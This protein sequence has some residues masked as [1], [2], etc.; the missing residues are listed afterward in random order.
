MKKDF[1]KFKKE[2]LKFK[3]ENLKKIV[4]LTLLLAAILFIIAMPIKKFINR[5][6]EGKLYSVRNYS[7]LTRIL[8]TKDRYDDDFL[9][10]L[11]YGIFGF[12]PP[13][14]PYTYKSMGTGIYEDIAIPQTNSATSVPRP[15]SIGLEG[16]SSTIDRGSSSSDYSKTNVQIENIDEADIIKTDGKYVYSISEDYIVISDVL[17]KENPKVLHKLKSPSSTYPVDLLINENKLVVFSTDIARGSYNSSMSIIQVFDLSDINFPRKIKTLELN[18][19]YN[20]SRMIDNN[21]YIFSKKRLLNEN[22]MAL[23]NE[24]K[25]DYVTKTINYDNVKY[26]KSNLTDVATTFI[27]LNLD[28][29]TSDVNIS[30]YLVDLDTAYISFDSIYLLNDDYGYST[31]DSYFQRIKG[32]FG[33]KGLLTDLIDNFLDDYMDFS[34]NDGR[35]TGITKYSF[36]KDKENIKFENQAKVKGRILNQY[37]LDEKDG[38]LRI[39]LK[40]NEGTRIKVL[41]D[42]LKEIG[43]TGAVAAGE[44]N[45]SV[46]FDGD[47]AYFVTY[48]VVDPLFVIDLSIA[49]KPRIVGE[50]EIPGFSNYLHPYDENHIIGIG[51]A[52]S[53]Q[54]VRDVFGRPIRENI[55]FNGMKMT[56]F[57]ISDLKN[58]REKDVIYFGDRS[59]DSPIN[60]N[61]KALL[62]SKEKNLIAIPV[63]NMSGIPSI[64]H[65]RNIDDLY[66]ERINS[67][68]II[69]NEAVKE[70]Y[71]VF[72][73][74]VDGFKYKGIV[75]HEEFS[76]TNSGNSNNSSNIRNPLRGL[77]IDDFLITVSNRLL[78]I[79]KLDTLDFVSNVDIFR[80]ELREEEV[81]NTFIPV[82]K[83]KVEEKQDLNN[84]YSEIDNDLDNEELEEELSEEERRVL[85]TV[86]PESI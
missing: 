77:Y 73:L 44:D 5:T 24:Y 49:D 28:D 54:V 35:Y 38:N 50:L 64:F 8:K 43:D 20:T 86:M 82:K 11:I 33:L 31:D 26:V 7:H 4:I 60:K 36:A 46:R 83:T 6:Q 2:D 16:P 32:V 52:T 41:N 61:A 1:F 17:D 74:T 21:I 75:T 65:D 85:N 59:T 84:N 67:K 68:E 37:S 51:M 42:K 56:M 69:I 72:E 53:E 78:K 27:S 40:D 80:K 14:I 79:N 15:S 81:G 57:D 18:A 39:A 48:K 58:P 70:G 55:T 19:E 12:V 10:E 66:L 71:I 9:P 3:K 25:E 45:K 23:F 30:S 34:F 47:R 62:Y 63:N 29:V 13:Y 22:Q 76:S